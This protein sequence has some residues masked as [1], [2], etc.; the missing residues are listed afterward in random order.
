MMVLIPPVF[1]VESFIDDN[2][3]GFYDDGELFSD[4]NDD[5]IYGDRPGGLHILNVGEPG[6]S[7]QFD[8]VPFYLNTELAGITNDNDDDGVLNPGESATLHFSTG[9]FGYTNELKNLHISLTPAEN[10]VSFSPTEIM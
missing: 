2:E 8:Y 5:G 1:L 3:N 4:G 7:I 9:L 10:W 6:D